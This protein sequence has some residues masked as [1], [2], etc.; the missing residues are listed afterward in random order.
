[1]IADDGSTPA[2]PPTRFVSHPSAQG[3]GDTEERLDVESVSPST[4]RP[5]G[6]LSVSGEGTSNCFLPPPP[7]FL[8]FF[9]YNC[10]CNCLH[11]PCSKVALKERLRRGLSGDTRSLA[12]TEVPCKLIVVLNGSDGVILGTNEG[13]ATNDPVS[14]THLTLPTS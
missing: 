5:A 14:Y 3:R 6:Q 9:L 8:I 4:E 10:T 13:R 12:M 2:D 7:F 11:S 1:M